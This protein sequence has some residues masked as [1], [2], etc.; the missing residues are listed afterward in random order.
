MLTFVSVTSFRFKLLGLFWLSSRAL[1]IELNAHG[2]ALPVC[3]RQA[4]Q[5]HLDA[6]RQEGC[7]GPP[8]ASA[9]GL[10]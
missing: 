1:G 2:R 10:V 8:V 5:L 9:W 7:R 4:P 6:V 3:I